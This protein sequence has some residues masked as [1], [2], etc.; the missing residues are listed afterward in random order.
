[1]KDL[2]SHLLPGVDDGSKSL[3]STRLLL[4]SAKKNG[5]TDIMFTPHYVPDSRFSSP[6]SVNNNIFKDVE[7]IA[8]EEYGI[9]IY[10]GNEVYLIPDIVDYLKTG[11]INSLNGSR[12]LLCEIPMHQKFNNLKSVFIEIMNL[13]Y[14]PILAH[15]ERYSAYFADIDFFMSLRRLGVLMQ[16]NITS[17][18]GDY[19]SKSKYMA[20]ELLKRNLISFVGSDIHDV[21][22][23]KYDKL[24]MSLFKLRWIVGKEKLEELT[25]TNFTCVVNNEDIG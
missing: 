17:L 20:K 21:K 23:M 19:G 9:N 15:P 12:Y 24:K 7:R 2:H 13:G 1:M 4:E 25:N 6:A 3:E 18:V 11:N 8:K 10:L 14:I 16:V 22:E 5:V